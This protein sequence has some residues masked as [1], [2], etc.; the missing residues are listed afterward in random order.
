MS[1]YHR[2]PNHQ[3][4][5]AMD[6]LS[7]GLPIDRVLA[8]VGDALVAHEVTTTPH[9]QTGEPIPTHRVTFD[10]DQVRHTEVHG[11]SFHSGF[12]GHIEHPTRE[13]SAA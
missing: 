6:W 13:G 12:V 10:A 9:W 3:I 4:L 11:R 1:D 5:V 8:F 2:P 7:A